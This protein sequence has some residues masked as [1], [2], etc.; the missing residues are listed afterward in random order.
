MTYEQAEE[1]LFRETRENG[2]RSARKGEGYGVRVGVLRGLVGA[3][4]CVWSDFSA[5][6][7]IGAGDSG[8]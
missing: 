6:S 4:S 1:G 2:D 3:F 7:G 8:R 5:V